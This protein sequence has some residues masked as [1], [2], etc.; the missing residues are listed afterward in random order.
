[1][2]RNGLEQ[3]AQRKRLEVAA[4]EEQLPQHELVQRSLQ[5]TEPRR[6]L[7]AALGGRELR[8]IA[9]IR[10]PPEERLEATLMFDPRYVAQEFAGAGAAAISVV[11]DDPRVGTEPHLLRRARRYMALPVMQWDWFVSEYQVY[12]A[13]ENRAD[14][15]A[16]LVGLV[17]DDTL[18]QMVRAASKLRIS[19]VPV[20]CDGFEVESALAADAEFIAISNRDPVTGDVDLTTTER[21]TPTIPGEVP[22]ISAHGITGREDAERVAAAGADAALFEPPHDYELAKDA[23]RDLRGIIAPGRDESGRPRTV[24]ELEED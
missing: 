10:R 7:K 9:E 5:D 6:N 16:L 14:A 19:A 15:V 17:D 4:E 18:Q 8:L 2:M 23:I 11:T 1:M 22:V 21:L 3:I 20:V 12:R 24:E 13:W